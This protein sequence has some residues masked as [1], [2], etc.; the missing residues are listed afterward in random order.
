MKKLLVASLLVVIG[1]A[2]FAQPLSKADAKLLHLKED[3]LKRYAVKLI[4]G[5]NASDRFTADSIFTRI[6]VRA[7]KTPGSFYYP[8]D[9]LETI[10]KLYPPDSSFKIFT[11]Q[12]MI[13][14]NVIRQHGA[15]QMRTADGSLKLYPLID[16]SDVTVN[17]VDTIGNNKGWMGAVY[18]NIVQKKSANQNYYTLLGFDENNIRSNRKI[19]E[20][21]HFNNEEPVFGGRYFSFE[22]DSVFKSSI[23][24]YIMEY[25]KTDGPKLNYD[26][27]MDMII[28][29]H[30]I[31]ESNEPNKKWTLI[32]D[33]DYEGFKW[34]N[35]KWVHIEKVFNQ[36]TPSGKEP[37]PNPIRSSDGTID[38]SKIKDP[39]ADENKAEKKATPSIK[40]KK[41]KSVTAKTKG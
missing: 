14:D 4:Q 16:K 27:E 19:I 37:V 40:P 18:Y 5:I 9:S 11:W 13:N 21:L 34:K 10:S 2:C 20:V 29:E 38:P 36:I 1:T 15:I 33:G 7:L 23:G 3:S 39:S 22:E 26:A 17:M 30:L 41:K 12:M 32:G 35:G 8:F 28:V 31:S 24:R 25:K 6:L